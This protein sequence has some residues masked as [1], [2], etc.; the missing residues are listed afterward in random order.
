MTVI[1]TPLPYGGE[2][3]VHVQAKA[4]DVGDLSQDR[5]INSPSP[6]GDCMLNFLLGA[7]VMGWIWLTVWHRQEMSKI[8]DKQIKDRLENNYF[9]P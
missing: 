3:H 9:G 5:F 2:A 1:R 6:E 8:K 4:K 7:S